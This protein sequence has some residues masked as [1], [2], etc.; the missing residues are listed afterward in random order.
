MGENTIIKYKTAR[1][2]Q[3]VEFQISLKFLGFYDIIRAVKETYFG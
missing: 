2:V 3:G 1:S